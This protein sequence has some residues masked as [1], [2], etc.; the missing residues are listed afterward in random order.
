MTAHLPLCG[1]LIAPLLWPS[2]AQAQTLAN[3]PATVADWGQRLIAALPDAAMLERWGN[4]LLPALP[5]WLG[6]LVTLF[7][8]RA[9]LARSRNALTLAATAASDR[10]GRLRTLARLALL[11]LAPVGL[12]V[13]VLVVWAVA[14]TPTTLQARVVQGMTLPLGAAA[15]TMALIDWVFAA[16]AAHGRMAGARTTGQVTWALGLVAC[17]L[18]LGLVLRSIGG[19]MDPLLAD[20]LGLVAET[21]AALVAWQAVRRH[22][23]TLRQLMHRESPTPSADPPTLPEQVI[24]AV[25]DRWHLLA[26]GFIVLGL[27]ARYGLFGADLRSGMVTDLAISLALLVA[28]GAGVL[29]AENLHGRILRHMDVTSAAGLRDRMALR[30]GRVLRTGVQ[31]ALTLWAGAAILMLW[32]P[33]IPLPS[34]GGP[35]L[36]AALTTLLALY[37][38]W[39]IWTLV[40]TVLDWSAARNLGRGTR[41]RTLLPFLRNFAFVVVATLSAMSVLSNLGVDVAP[42]LAG[43]GVVGIAI[44]IGAQKL[45]SDV[46]TGIFILFEDSVAI[47]ETVE[48]AGKTGVI[49]G[50]TIRTLRLR[51]GDGA[52]HS[53]PFSSITTLKNSSR[54]YSAYTINVTILHPEDT[55]RALA[56]VSRIGEDIARDP[57]W[58]ASVTGPFSLWG[59]DQ[60]SPAG[61]VIKGNIRSHP[62]AQWGLGRE[63][64]R[65][66]A[67]RFSELGISQVQPLG[68]WA[69]AEGARG[70]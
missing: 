41:M 20:L 17:L 64:N 50:L 61:V 53:I 2:H 4:T 39:F 12:A 45:V 30:L 38:L 19:Q 54:G 16:L 60:I 13:L 8:G 66:I 1:W 27:M 40:D 31:I 9:A 36:R 6:V 21:L 62:N 70:A 67:L 11:S 68:S 35:L 51:D 58:A 32:S 10:A 34:G 56:E 23:D 49:E 33:A 24:A 46:I 52:L 29:M 5:I 69:G 26:C 55:D 15:L 37:A 22:R 42:L 7:G 57:D 44:G 47:G 65:R 3:L 59:V 18:A 48:A 14:S 28:A 63:I 43:A 25:A